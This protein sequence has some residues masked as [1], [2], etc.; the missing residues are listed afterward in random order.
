M[1]EKSM[2]SAT[3]RGRT[4]RQVLGRHY[5]ASPGILTRI[6]AAIDPDPGDLIIEIGP[7]LGALTFPLA[8]R[9]GRIVAVEKDPEAV[10]QLRTQPVPNVDL[11]EGDILGVDLP[12]LAARYRGEA[13][14]IKL[15]GN[16][17]YSISSPLLYK[18]LEERA[19]FDQAGFLVQKE[20][21]EKVC[22]RPGTKDYG[23][24]S[25]R[26]QA[27]F[28]ARIEFSVRPGAFVPPPKVDSAFFTLA[29]R[30]MSAVTDAEERE[31]GR[32]LR[33]A[34]RQR[35]RTLRNNLGA[36]GYAAARIDEALTGAGIPPAARPEAVPIDAFVALF[37]ELKGCPGRLTD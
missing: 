4:K 25:I 36:A 18:V 19:A 9:A 33:A 30:P 35:R 11:I 5:L 3:P 10:R 34:F 32:F 6:M 2:R 37:R 26:L 12:S 20:V 21:A 23:P 13:R 29:K 17:P 24:L 22:A 31:F 8:G 1:S 28:I 27:Q 16:L 7:G 15:V 14:K